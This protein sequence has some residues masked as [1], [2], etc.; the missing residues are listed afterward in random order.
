VIAR[1]DWFAGNPELFSA[2]TFYPLI[3]SGSRRNGFRRM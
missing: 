2:S 1:P 3:R